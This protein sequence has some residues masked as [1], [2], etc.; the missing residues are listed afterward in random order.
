MGW[1]GT[2]LLAV[3]GVLGVCTGAAFA[4]GPRPE[5]APTGIGGGVRPEPVPISPAATP[6]AAPAR[7]SQVSSGGSQ[8][9]GGPTRGSVARFQPPAVPLGGDQRT[10][11]KRTSPP[12]QTASARSARQVPAAKATKRRI[13]RVVKTVAGKAAAP[14]RDL[15]LLGGAA[16]LVLAVGEALFLALSLRFLRVTAEP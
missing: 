14:D 10:Q 8:P 3:I 16:L 4:Q 5:P 12:K 15:L 2:V 9:T 1:R 7:A 11:V 6:P 13:E